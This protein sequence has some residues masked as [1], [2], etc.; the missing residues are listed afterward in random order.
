MIIVSLSLL[1]LASNQQIM[2]PET[3]M[4]QRN[5]FPDV[6]KLDLDGSNWMI[7][8][9]RILRAIAARLW[10][11]HIE[12]TAV[13]PASIVLPTATAPTTQDLELIERNLDRQERWDLAQQSCLDL[14]TSRI[15][16]STL[17]RLRSHSTPFAL[18]TALEAE[19]QITSDLIR[20]NFWTQLGNARCG[21]NGN[22]RDHCNKMSENRERYLA[23]G[24]TLPD[25]DFT[26]MLLSSLP[27]SYCKSLN[28]ILTVMQQS[29]TAAVVT[30]RS[31]ARNT[32]HLNFCHQLC[33]PGV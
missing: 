28:M 30:P 23:M 9:E 5:N 1:Q 13:R 10:K 3:V 7:F 11:S 27:E 20:S 17:L 33:H 18:W 4:S 2:R 6:P 14:I 31:C 22:V 26:N 8:R 25:E 24:G 32:H 21:N 12:G 16:D 19:N 29:H 15:P